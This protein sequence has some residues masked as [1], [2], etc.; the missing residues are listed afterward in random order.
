[1]KPTDAEDNHVPPTEEELARMKEAAERTRQDAHARLTEY[2]DRERRAQLSGKMAMWG[3]AALAGA[4]VVALLMQEEPRRRITK[5]FKRLNKRYKVS[6]RTDDL[7]ARIQSFI[8]D[9][10]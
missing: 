8:H 1:M 10:S 6:D 9:L 7:V 2:E 4:V 3:I 5:S